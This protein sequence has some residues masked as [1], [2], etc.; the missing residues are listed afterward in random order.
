MLY[1]T[2]PGLFKQSSSGGQ[3]SGSPN[4]VEFALGKYSEGIENLVFYPEIS[5]R[6]DNHPKNNIGQDFVMKVVSNV[7]TDDNNTPDDTTDDIQV[8]EYD[9]YSLKFLVW[10]QGSNRDGWNITD[11]S[12]TYTRSK[13]PLANSSG[14]LRIKAGEKSATY[15]LEFPSDLVYEGKESLVKAITITNSSTPDFSKT[16]VVDDFVEINTSISDTSTLEGENV[17]VSASLNEVRSIETIVN[18][19]LSGTADQSDIIAQN[20]IPKNGIETLFGVNGFDDNQI[21]DMVFH[22]G[23]IYFSVGRGGI[24][25]INSDNTYSNVLKN[26][27]NP[28]YR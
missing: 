1:N 3:G 28:Y 17:T 21:S 16:L 12:V 5:N 19:S 24:F 15:T 7:T 13:F 26:S 11:T 10:D 6:Y 20:D 27:S 4:G 9:Y 25:K 22:N 8:Y 14:S 23:V 2:A 18:F